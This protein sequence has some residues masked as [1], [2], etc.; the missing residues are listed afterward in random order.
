MAKKRS[1]PKPPKEENPVQGFFTL[2]GLLLAACT[3]AFYSV[4]INVEFAGKNSYAKAYDSRI[5][6]YAERIDSLSKIG[7]WRERLFMRHVSNHFIPTWIAEN[8]RPTD[9]ILLP[10]AGYANK[11]MKADAIW[12]DPR[13]FTYFTNFQPIIAYTDTAR[14]H[15][16]NSWILLEEGSLYI[17]RR[18]GNYDIDSLIDVYATDAQPVGAK[19]SSGADR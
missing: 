7:S 9:T 5:G 4:L 14:W 17:T 15:K 16:A 6:F 19:Q 10:P 12:T 13:I 11:Y 18:G 2:K 1:A 3:L 8:R